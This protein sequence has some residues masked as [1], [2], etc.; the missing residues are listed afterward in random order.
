M[1]DFMRIMLRLAVMSL[2]VMWYYKTGFAQEQKPI[3]DS[4]VQEDMSSLKRDVAAVLAEQRQIL[5]QLNEL[6]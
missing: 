2:I 3:T 6:R 5:Q 4:S 1:N